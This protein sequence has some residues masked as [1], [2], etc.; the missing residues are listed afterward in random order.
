[1]RIN[2]K[3]NKNQEKIKK[4]FNLLMIIIKLIKNNKLNLNKNNNNNNKFNKY[5]K[6][7]F[8][9]YNKNKFKKF[10]KNKIKNK[11]KKYLKINLKFIK[12]KLICL[13]KLKKVIYYMP[14]ILYK[15]LLVN[16][17]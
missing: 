5:N 15:I 9:K 1:M 12:N 11:Y 14:K 4:L 13:K 7:K 3:K 10:N 17:F 2:L 8:K 6:N 16:S